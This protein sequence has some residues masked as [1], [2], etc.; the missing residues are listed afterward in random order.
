MQRLSSMREA[1]GRAQQMY[2]QA[3]LHRL[4]TKEDPVAI[5]CASRGIA[6]DVAQRF[7][8]GW[9]QDGATLNMLRGREALGV[10]AGLLSDL[11]QSDASPGRTGWK[12]RLRN[13]LTFPITDD[14]GRVIAFGGRIIE[15]GSN[16]PKY[17]NTPE[18]DLYK[19]SEALFRIH[20]ARTAINRSKRAI[21][22][23][24]LSLIHI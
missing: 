21:V 7:G 17:L 19:K 1:L 22:V 24:G 16:A 20:D 2:T 6:P 9:A 4:N 13:R 3:L 15:S 5:Y 23:E 14:Q 10:D 12:D 8:L 11:S 18:T